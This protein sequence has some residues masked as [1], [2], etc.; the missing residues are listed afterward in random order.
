MK[1]KYFVI[2]LSADG[3]HYERFTTSAVSFSGACKTAKLFSKNSGMTIK[4]IIEEKT[5]SDS[6]N[7]P[8]Y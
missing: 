7:L 5:L 4:G 6:F 3:K 1:K 2:C 8:I